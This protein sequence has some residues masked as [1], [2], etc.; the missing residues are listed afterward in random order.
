MGMPIAR[1]A[2]E[3]RPR[4]G[5]APAARVRGHDRQEIAGLR[6][7]AAELDLEAGDLLGATVLHEVTH[8][9]LD[10]QGTGATHPLEAAHRRIARAPDPPDVAGTLRAFRP[11]FPTRS[12]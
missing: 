2:V 11:A 9:I 4:R 3:V 1:A 8:R 10:R 6:L 7:L 5:R 12:P